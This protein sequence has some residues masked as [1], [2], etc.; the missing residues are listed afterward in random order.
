MTKVLSI[1]TPTEHYRQEFLT[2]ILGCLRLQIVGHED[3]VEHIILTDGGEMCLGK[4][5]NLLYSIV[6]GKYV[7]VVN[8]DDLLPDNYISILLEAVKSDADVILGKIKQSWVKGLELPSIIGKDTVYIHTY[9]NVMPAKTELV[10]A[11]GVWDERPENN[12]KQDTNL[13]IKV[14]DAAKSVHKIDDII[15]YHLRQETKTDS[16]LRSKGK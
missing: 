14:F 15:Y 10:R 8:D 1:V 2:R 7:V 6:S 4:K 13:S 11:H 3:E 5:M 9:E 16:H 12:Y